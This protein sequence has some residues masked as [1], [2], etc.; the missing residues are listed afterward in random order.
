MIKSDTRSKEDLLKL[1]YNLK[2]TDSC[3]LQKIE[4]EKKENENRKATVEQQKL[5][6]NEIYLSLKKDEECASKGLGY[7]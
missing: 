5:Q 6:A 1:L 2:S 3:I 7:A 4:E